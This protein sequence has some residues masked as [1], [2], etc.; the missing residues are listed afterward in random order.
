[1]RNYKDINDYELMYLIAEKDDEASDLM[2]KKYAPIVESTALRYYNLYKKDN[3]GL[4]LADFIQEGYVG[5]FYAIKNY[6]EDK[7]CLFY[8]YATISIKS[9]IINLIKTHSSD[10]NKVLNNAIS[11]NKNIDSDNDTELLEIVG[12]DKALMPEVELEK[13]EIYKKIRS[14]LY[15]L[16]IRES[17]ILEMKMNGFSNKDIA[18]FLELRPRAVINA[19]RII[20]QKYIH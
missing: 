2:Y 12:D 8:T 19:Y 20:R 7:N 17:S 5:L 9:K 18:C 4:E 10:K 16:S 1:M 15:T 13:S 11:L 3:N 6:T 14:F